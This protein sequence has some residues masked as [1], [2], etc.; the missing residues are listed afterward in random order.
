MYEVVRADLRRSLLRMLNFG[1][2][3]MTL[4]LV[5][6]SWVILSSFGCRWQVP[7]ALIIVSTFGSHMRKLT[8]QV[9]VVMVLAERQDV[10]E[11]RRR[12]DEQAATRMLLQLSRDRARLAAFEDMRSVLA[13]DPSE[14]V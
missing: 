11:Q 3:V 10:A 1:L 8:L 13:G 4:S 6:V 9:E 14:E 2:V 5:R 12:S 7:A